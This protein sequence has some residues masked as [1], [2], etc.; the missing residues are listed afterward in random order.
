MNK[1][2]LLTLFVLLLGIQS[3]FSFKKDYQKYKETKSFFD[4]DIFIK[5]IAVIICCIGLLMYQI[6]RRFI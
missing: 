6:I 4:F 2:D 1:L 3:F 5:D